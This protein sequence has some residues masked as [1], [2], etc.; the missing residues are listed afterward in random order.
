MEKE[1]GQWS[2]FVAKNSSSSAA[3]RELNAEIEEEE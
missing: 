2:A 1:R 3:T